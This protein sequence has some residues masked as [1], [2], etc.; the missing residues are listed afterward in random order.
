MYLEE[1]L[2]QTAIDELLRIEEYFDRFGVA[3]VITVGRVSDF[4]ARVSDS[5]RN[6]A[7]EAAYQILH[8]PKTAASKDCT[9]VRSI[10][11]VTPSFA[12]QTIRDIYR[13]PLSQAH[14]EE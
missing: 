6:D 4:A 13:T 14:R 3:F 2:Q 10:D 9:L 5:S 12:F 7:R 8:P 11:V 1:E